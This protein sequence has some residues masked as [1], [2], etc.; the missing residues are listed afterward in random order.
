MGSSAGMP[1][2]E[3]VELVTGYLDDALPAAERARC[4]E[5][6][7]TCAGCRA[8]L[9]HMEVVV[10]ALGELRHSD[11]EARGAEKARLLGLFRARGLH[12]RAPLERSVPL[13]IADAFATPGDHIGYFWEDDQEFDATADFL[14]T[15]LERDEVCVLLGHDA[16]NARVLAGLERRGLSPDDMRRRD[17]FHTVA[18][19]QPADALKHRR[20]PDESDANREAHSYRRRLPRRERDERASDNRRRA[21]LEPVAMPSGR[22]MAQQKRGLYLSHLE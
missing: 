9:A 16:A 20:Q 4:D 15:G 18:G 12:N 2:Q 7:R 21:D 17:R 22:L 1:C 6:L 13:G 10:S 5:H 19:Q 14:A 11:G 3:L 8:Y